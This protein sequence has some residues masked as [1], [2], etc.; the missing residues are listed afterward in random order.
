MREG[1]GVLTLN[2]KL[3]VII[4]NTTFSRKSQEFIIIPVQVLYLQS[5]MYCVV[6]CGS[7][8]ITYR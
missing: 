8:N 3:A 7:T 5:F 4:V 1:G 6:S 2:M